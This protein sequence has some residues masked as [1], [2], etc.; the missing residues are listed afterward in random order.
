MGGFQDSLGS[1]NRVLEAMYRLMSVYE[2]T[3]EDLGRP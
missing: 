1:H 3:H 2:H